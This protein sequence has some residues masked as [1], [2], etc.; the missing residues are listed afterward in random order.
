MKHR[1]A[2]AVRQWIAAQI[3][4]KNRNVK[5]LRDKKVP[6]VSY[7]EESQERQNLLKAKVLARE[8]TNEK[9]GHVETRPIIH[10]E[11]FQVKP[12]G[13]PSPP[14]EQRRIIQAATSSLKMPRDLQSGPTSSV[15]TDA[16]LALPIASS[17]CVDLDPTTPGTNTMSVRSSFKRTRSNRPVSQKRRKIAGDSSASS[18][19]EASSHRCEPLG[20]TAEPNGNGEGMLRGGRP[21]VTNVNHTRTSPPLFDERYPEH[22][23]C[24]SLRVSKTPSI[25][26]HESADQDMMT[27]GGSPPTP[28]SQGESLHHLPGEEQNT[29]A[30]RILCS[31]GTAFR[32]NE[33]RTTSRSAASAS[34]SSAQRSPNKTKFRASSPSR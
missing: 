12:E 15:S 27:V 6:T 18:W 32:K 34:A 23:R 17:F 19:S 10:F 31:S 33:G 22:A 20:R 21:N 24:A 26:G 28:V 3:Q 14:P 11:N 16:H 30:D 25:I 1:I 2:L 8:D 7:P 29:S 4:L 5:R 9:P 13:S